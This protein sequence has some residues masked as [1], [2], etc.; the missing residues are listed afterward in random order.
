LARE[1]CRRR[2]A[3][4]RTLKTWRTFGKGWN[5]RVAD[6]QRVAVAMADKLELPAVATASMGQAKA[7][8]AQVSPVRRAAFTSAGRAQAIQI[9][10][11]AGGALTAISDAVRPL[12]ETWQWVGIASV[13]LLVGGTVALAIVKA[14]DAPDATPKP[15]AA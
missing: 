6:V 8:P 12:S 13:V 7:N 3:W 10:G 5:S 4:V 15:E 2:L 14:M 11:A 9:A 1:V